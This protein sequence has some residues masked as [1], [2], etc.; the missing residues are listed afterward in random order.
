M[1]SQK[2]LMLEA[3]GQPIVLVERPIPTPE[4]GQILIKVTVIGLNPYDQR[5]R[6]WGLYVE[7]C[8]PVVLGNDIAGIVHA[9]G[10]NTSTSLQVGDHVFGQTN[11]L[12]KDKLSDQSGLQEFC[13]LEAYTAA[14]IPKNLTDDDGA[15]LVCNIVAPFWAIFGS[16]GL[17]LPFPFTDSDTSLDYS[18]ETIVII[19]A[20]GNCGKYA[21]Q[22]CALAGFSRIVVTASKEK[23]EEELLAYGA[24]HVVDRNGS[25][26]EVE[27]RIREIVGDDL[28]YAT[29]A[30]NVDHTLGLSI[31]SSTKRG[32][33]SCLVPTMAELGDI[34]EKKAGYEEKFIHGQSHNDPELAK[35]LWTHLPRWMEE[36]K[37]RATGWD[38]VNGLDADAI[39]AVLDVYRDGKVP[40][41]QY[42]KVPPK[43]VHVHLT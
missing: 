43:Q 18:K 28:I 4:E 24:T 30:V 15:S 34:G 14:K 22:L 36:G 25:K 26:E 42:G 35:K 21:V 1:G 27:G 5:V 40:F 8:L 31:L 32:T 20:G 3:I 10:P 38:V 12:K 16:G 11:Y 17:G 41:N 13:I 29:D 33:L 2:A 19:G 6:D 39:N 37:I 7:D 9:I 23:N